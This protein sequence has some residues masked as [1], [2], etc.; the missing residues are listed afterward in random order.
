MLLF[1]YYSELNDYQ[2]SL[3]CT[4]NPLSEWLLKGL[5]CNQILFFF[6]IR[7]HIWL[8]ILVLNQNWSQDF[9]VQVHH[10]FLKPKLLLNSWELLII[11]CFWIIRFSLSL[12]IR[13]FSL[14][15][16]HHF[17]N[18]LLALQPFFKHNFL[19]KL[20]FLS[21]LL[22][23]TY[24]IFSFQ[25]IKLFLFLV[26]LRNNILCFLNTFIFSFLFLI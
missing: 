3:L 15:G 12:F 9:L 14:L 7:C 24:S 17:V 23:H 18:S 13:H 2:I 19:K 25:N 20:L 21:L 10:K 4:F 11:I 8:V 26:I 6:R 5:S 16:Q 1:I 22:Y